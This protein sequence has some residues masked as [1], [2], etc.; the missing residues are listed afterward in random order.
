[1]S[2]GCAARFEP[3]AGDT[4]AEPATTLSAC[5]T[6]PK[7]FYA[8]RDLGVQLIERETFDSA[9]MR[10]KEQLKYECKT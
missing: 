8:V 3:H 5:V 10:K 2:C 4:P 7:H 6:K 1:M 9:L